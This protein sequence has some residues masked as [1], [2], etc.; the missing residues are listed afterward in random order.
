ML[1]EMEHALEQA[2]KEQAVVIPLLLGKWIDGSTFRK[3]SAFDTSVYADASHVHPRAVPGNTVRGTLDRIF[4]LQ[5][6]FGDPKDMEAIVGKVA[7]SVRQAATRGG[8]E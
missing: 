5:G 2:E 8:G 6:L 3:F 7:A 1:L 4:K